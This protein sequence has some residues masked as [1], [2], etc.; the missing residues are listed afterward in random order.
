M[1][2]TKQMSSARANHASEIQTLRDKLRHAFTQVKSK[3]TENERL[4]I[5]IKRLDKEVAMNQTNMF[6][7]GGSTSNQTPL[8]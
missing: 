2:H 5:K 6:G 7:F 3:E 4:L 1:Q 8:M